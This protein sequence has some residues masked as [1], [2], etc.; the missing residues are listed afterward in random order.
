M[1]DRS[2]EVDSLSVVKSTDDV[3]EHNDTVTVV[4]GR[5]EVYL[6]I[7]LS[8]M[9]YLVQVTPNK[10]VKV[11]VTEKFDEYFVIEV[12]IKEEVEVDYCIKAFQP[13]YQTR[14]AIYGELQGEESPKAVTTEEMGECD[15]E[16]YCHETMRLDA[17]EGDSLKII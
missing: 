16:Q 6:P 4:N 9:G 12:D 7:G 13:K 8:H 17:V 10:L 15:E 11:A 14:T 1:L 5:A 2:G 3:I